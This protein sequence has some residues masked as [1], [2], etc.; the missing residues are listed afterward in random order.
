MKGPFIRT[1]KS[2]KPLILFE[3]EGTYPYT[4]G[5]VSTWAHILI[6]KLENDADFIIYTLTGGPNVESR[7]RLSSNVRDI[8]HL[9]L[10]GTVE[11]SEVFDKQR[12][13]SYY[14]Q[15]KYDTIF[16]NVERY[17]FPLM[18]DFLN[19]LFDPFGP[20]EKASEIL[21]GLW[22]Y[23]MH[24]DFKM[25]IT[26]PNLWVEF[27]EKLSGYFDLKRDDI[28][29]GEKPV[30]FDTVFSLRWLYHFLMPLSVPL[31]KVDVTHATIAGFAGLPGILA[32]YEHGTPLIVT[33]HG[34]FIRERLIA[35]SRADFPYYAKKFLIDLST[36]VSRSIYYTATQ[37]SP[38]AH[39]NTKWETRYE[40]HSDKIKVIYNG[41]DPHRF[42][43][44][45][46]PPSTR[47]R[48][49][50][51]AAA[52]V[53]ALKDIATMIRTC[54]IVRKTIPNVHFIVYGSLY[55]DPE[56]VNQCR[57]LINSLDLNYNFTFGGFHQNPAMLYNEG[58]ISILTSISEG[59]P[60]TV[61]ESMACGRPVVATD[62]G[63]VR[64]ALEGCGIICKP[65][66]AAGLARGVIK[67]LQDDFLRFELGKKAREKVL[68]NF[69][70]D[71]SVNRYLESYKN[72]AERIAVPLK[73]N[74]RLESVKQI[75]E[76]DEQVRSTHY[77]LSV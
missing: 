50:V 64:E 66:D 5:G 76:F 62:V 7:F 35:I 65:K 75:L 33:D 54:N 9:P 67:L 61:I 12:R 32:A 55:A 18:D 22:K 56:Y 26:H 72:L 14:L 74:V 58:D 68:L 43:P 2:E 45:P 37:I 27:K 38:V 13:F 40:A 47:F 31:P 59:F 46:K 30:L 34:V 71:V 11:P 39:Y 53:Y 51:V 8:I 73:E 17:F 69:T 10:W 23:F 52:R 29:P 3:T 57:D 44:A 49:T 63:G 41:I 15:K 6:H 4:G 70:E 77:R 21:Y 36:V 20:P 48:P 60:Y 16:K 24:F 28:I 25:T 1:I 19:I 42:K